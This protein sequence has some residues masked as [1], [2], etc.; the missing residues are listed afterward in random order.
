MIPLLK[1]SKGG[2]C[3]SGGAPGVFSKSNWAGDHAKSF[4][5]EERDNYSWSENSSAYYSPIFKL[6]R[7]VFRLLSGKFKKRVEKKKLEFGN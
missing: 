7:G 6:D 3:G 2:G 4:F 5:R 1:S